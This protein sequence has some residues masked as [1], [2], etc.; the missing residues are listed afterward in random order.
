MKNSP[1][2]SEIPQGD[3]R[4]KNKKFSPQDR[5]WGLGWAAVVTPPPILPTIQ[6]PSPKTEKPTSSG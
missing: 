2:G 6:K 3:F 5:V 4:K 1:G